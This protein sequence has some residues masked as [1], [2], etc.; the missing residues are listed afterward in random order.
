MCNKNLKRIFKKQR[1]P[2]KIVQEQRKGKRKVGKERSQSEQQQ[3][4]NKKKVDE[5]ESSEAARMSSH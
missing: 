2:R 1:H 4:R 5:G 3:E